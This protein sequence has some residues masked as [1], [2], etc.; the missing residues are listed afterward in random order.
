MSGMSGWKTYANKRSKSRRLSNSVEK[1]GKHSKAAGTK[2]KP[3]L[4]RNRGVFSTMINIP[5]LAEV[6]KDCHGI[7]FKYSVKGIGEK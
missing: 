1:R 4:N 3:L 6:I 5:I 7:G 2:S